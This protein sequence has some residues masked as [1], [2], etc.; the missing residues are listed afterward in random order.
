MDDRSWIIIVVVYIRGDEGLKWGS[1]EGIEK[2]GKVK[3]SWED[4]IDNLL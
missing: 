3:R 1:V 2:G 4:R